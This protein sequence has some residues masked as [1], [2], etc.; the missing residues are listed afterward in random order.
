LLQFGENLN[1]FGFFIEANEETF[2]SLL[3]NHGASRKVRCLRKF[4]E[5]D[6]TNRLDRLIQ[7]AGFPTDFDLLSI[8]IDGAD[9]FVWESLNF[10]RPRVVVIEFNPSIP[11]DVVFVQ[12]RDMNVNQGSSLLA[13][14]FPGKQKGYELICCTACNA[15][16]VVKEFFSLFG[17]ESNHITKLFVPA[18]DGRIFHGFDSYIHVT[19]MPRLIWSGTAVESDDFQ[20][21]PASLRRFGDAQSRVISIEK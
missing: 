3:R 18:S 20:V 15:F 16:F 11:N 9:Y 19:G 12:A 14:T 4:V 17:L 7:E 21:I 8:D 6:G 13:L 1:W 10:F 2:E 5:F